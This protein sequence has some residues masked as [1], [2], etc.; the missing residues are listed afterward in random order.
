MIV[1]EER[2]TVGTN[3]FILD[4]ESVA[5]DRTLFNFFMNAA[6]NDN[7][8]YNLREMKVKKMSKLDSHDD[9]VVLVLTVISVEFEERGLFAL[10]VVR[11]VRCEHS[12]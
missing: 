5:H 8:M 3:T 4:L 2:R 10:F 11:T 9:S 7:I 12:D 1:L 6:L